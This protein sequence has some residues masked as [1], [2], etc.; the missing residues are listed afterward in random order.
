MRATAI[1]GLVT[2]LELEAVDRTSVELVDL[3]HEDTVLSDQ[4]GPSLFGLPRRLAFGD[5][6]AALL[7]GKVDAVF[8]KGTAGVAAANLIGAIAV[9][10]FGFHPDPAVRINSGSPRILTVDDRLAEERPDL[11]RRLIGI[12]VQAGDW[13]AGHPEETRRFIAR[14]SHASEEAVLAANGADVHRNLG[15]SL[16]PDLLDAVRRFKDFLLEWDFIERDFDV[17]AWAD[18]RA[19]EASERRVA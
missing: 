10:K 17:G 8:V 18:H 19:W 4:E 6:C 2:A 1:K 11:V 7:R 5:E 12:I 15:L 3:V 16:R 14:E 9:S 13:A